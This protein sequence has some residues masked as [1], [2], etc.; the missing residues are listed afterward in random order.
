M[1]TVPGPL[2]YWIIGALAVSLLGLGT[3]STG[4]RAD[5]AASISPAAGRSVE[6]GHYCDGCTPPLLYQGG[7]VMDTSGSAGVTITPIYWAPAGYTFPAGYVSAINGYIKNVAAA[8]GRTDNVV[9][10]ASEYYGNTPA[11]KTYLRYRITAGAPVTDSTPYSAG[12]RPSSG[13]YSVCLTDARIRAELAAAIKQLRLKTGLSAFY[14]VFLPP[15]VET[16][17]QDGARSSNVY[18]GYHGVFGKGAAAVLYGN[19]PYEPEGCDAGQAPNGSLATDAAITTLS[20]ELMET[21]TDP[22]EPPAW[23]DRSGDEIGDIC[24]DDYGPSLGSTDPNDPAHTQYNQVIN[25]GKYYTQT[26]FSN[27]AY[28][29]FGVGNGCQPSAKAAARGAVVD[30]TIFLSDVY[31]SSL[32]A[33]GKAT[34]DDQI[35]VWDKRTNDGIKDQIALSTHVVDGKGNCGELNKTSG[36][37]D[38]YGSLDI[39]YTASTDNVICGIVA[40]EA[41]GGKSSTALVYQGSFRAV[42]PTASDTFPTSVRAGGTSYFTVTFGNRTAKKLPFATIDFN[43]FQATNASPNVTAAQIVMGTSIRG[44]GGPFTELKLTG[45]TKVDGAIQGRFVGPTG[46]GLTI[47]AHGKITVTFGI[48]LAKSVPSRGS[49]PVLSFEA[50]LDQLNPATGSGSTLAD[51][52]STDVAVLPPR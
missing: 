41:K 3:A 14:P 38:A 9:S 51:T 40:N 37:T 34:A 12:C 23:L 16:Q 49:K 5:R 35:L 22:A 24:A 28:A 52:E 50:Y 19:E 8:S 33:S 1:E 4:S 7:S 13:D 43:I 29:K 30:R 47:P 36:T 27:A 42:A 21:L 20:H 48:A 31:P 46:T 6:S 45:S 2:R 18:C 17:D 26:E 11:G 39:T 32:P 10:I 15:R 44:R 25:G